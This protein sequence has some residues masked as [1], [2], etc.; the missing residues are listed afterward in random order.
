MIRFLFV[1]LL[2]STSCFLGGSPQPPIHVADEDV[3]V[4]SDVKFP[5]DAQWWRTSQWYN[6]ADMATPSRVVISGEFACVQDAGFTDNPRN[7]DAFHC[8]G[9][10]RAPGGH[11]RFQFNQVLPSAPPSWM[12]TMR[13]A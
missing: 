9:G 11:P 2:L 13:W 3:M 1:A 10:W 8:P 7:G 5:V 4:V 6:S 12:P